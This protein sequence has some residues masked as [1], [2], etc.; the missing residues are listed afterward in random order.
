MKKSVKFVALLLAAVLLL[1]AL[2]AC[3]DR[4][5]TT[6]KP[7]AEQLA[8]MSE[9]ERAFKLLEVA[10]EGVLGWDSYTEETAMEIHMTVNGSEMNVSSEMTNKVQGQN[11]ASML[12]ASTETGSVSVAGQSMQSLQKQGYQNGKMYFYYSEDGEQKMALT[13][14]ISASGYRDYMVGQEDDAK[15]LLMKDTQACSATTIAKSGGAWTVKLYDFGQSIMDE[16]LLKMGL[17]DF[18]EGISFENLALTADITSD[19]KF[20]KISMTCD[21]VYNTGV[22]AGTEMTLSV[23]SEYKSVN[24][25]TVVASD[26]AGYQEVADLRVLDALQNALIEMRLANEGGFTFKL[27]QKASQ[28][29]QSTTYSEE[30]EMSY[31]WVNDKYTFEIKN[32]TG[33]E[34]YLVTY[35]DGAQ[36]VYR[37]TG[38]AQLLMQTSAITETQAIAYIGQFMDY[39]GFSYY[40]VIDV[41]KSDTKAN[42]Y[43][44]SLAVSDA[45]KQNFKPSAYGYSYNSGTLEITVSFEGDKL[46]SY[47]TSLTLVYK[48]GPYTYKYE[49]TAK[50]AYQ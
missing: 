21:I 39:A 17:S 8:S 47:D 32:K 6:T 4:K 34:T 11:T 19:Y 2:V 43:V 10:E 14:S 44:I 9:K 29:A 3:K 40:D 22:V 5:T 50:A 7:I 28:G 41:K 31:A 15:D 25:T 27:N 13:S 33:N 49:C 30:N 23:V 18:A 48:N 12:H 42:T 45:M 26:L 1:P 37:V 20:Q 16:M 24:S 38:E 36:K 35:A 46:V